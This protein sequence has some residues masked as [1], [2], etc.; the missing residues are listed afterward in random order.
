MGKNYFTDEQI[1]DLESNP[2]IENVT[3]KSIKYSEEFKIEFWNRY[4]NN[5]ESPSVI[6]TSLG[7]DP[8]ILGVKRISNIVQ[9]IKKESQRLEGFK[10]TRKH[11]NGRPKTKDMTPEE[12]I[13]YL[14][15]KIAYQ[16]QEIEF[17]K[18]IRFVEKK[19]HWIQQKKNTKSSKK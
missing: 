6:L 3:K 12:K 9:R 1:K 15:H 2:Y 17:L 10:D 7:I 19:E 18:K 16:Q 8:H 5:D 13:A 4:N 14:E 11:N